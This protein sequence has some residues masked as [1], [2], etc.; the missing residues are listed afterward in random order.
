[1]LA[2]FVV[3]DIYEIMN[4]T[5]FVCHGSLPDSRELAALVG[6]NGANHIMVLYLLD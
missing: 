5:L 2:E 6:Q 1:M 3:F 4:N